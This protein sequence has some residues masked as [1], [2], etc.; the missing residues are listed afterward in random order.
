MDSINT[1]E[2]CFIWTVMN[3]T[4]VTEC[5][6]GCKLSMRESCLTRYRDKSH[7]III[8]IIIIIV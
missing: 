8:I 4:A 5:P 1:N 3:T 6:G 7:I 2:V